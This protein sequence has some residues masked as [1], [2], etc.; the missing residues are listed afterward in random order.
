MAMCKIVRLKF[1]NFLATSLK[2]I[3]LMS[4]NTHFIVKKLLQ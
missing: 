1:H 3:S 4:L 2:N